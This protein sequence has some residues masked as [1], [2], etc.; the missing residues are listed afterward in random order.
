M[1]LKLPNQ[2]L[3]LIWTELVNRLLWCLNRLTN[4]SRLNFTLLNGSFFTVRN[5]YCKV[6][7]SVINSD[8]LNR[9]ELRI[10]NIG[11]HF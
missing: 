8:K 7:M 4:H 11:I 9:N 1:L 6:P 2:S 3:C 10:T 5:K